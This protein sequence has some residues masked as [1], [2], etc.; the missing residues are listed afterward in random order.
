M[1]KKITRRDFCNGIAI[2]TGMSLLSPMDLFGQI[3][4]A[5]QDLE[6]SYYPPILT[7]MRGS[8]KGSFEVAHALAWTGEKPA[9]YEKLDEEYD[10]VIVG[11][12]ISGLAAAW[13]YQ[14]K[15]GSDARILL[16]DNLRY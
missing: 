2:G 16:L 1:I 13:F 6:Q 10:L 5:S 12:G 8:H 9:K 7:G 15:I 11:A 14:K 4:F 3:A